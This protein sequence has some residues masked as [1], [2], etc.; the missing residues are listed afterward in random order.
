MIR[1]VL[2]SH[3]LRRATTKTGVLNALENNMFLLGITAQ[4]CR[5]L[6]SNSRLVPFIVKLLK[7]DEIVAKTSPFKPVFQSMMS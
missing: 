4:K 1:S 7:L 5:Q 3:V 2:S 6:S